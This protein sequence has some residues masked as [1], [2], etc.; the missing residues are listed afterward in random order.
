MALTDATAPDDAM[1]IDRFTTNDREGDER[2]A[3]DARLPALSA[4]D[5]DPD[6]VIPEIRTA[7]FWALSELNDVMLLVC[8]YSV[9]GGSSAATSTSMLDDLHPDDVPPTA[10]VLDVNDVAPSN[11]KAAAS[12]VASETLAVSVMPDGTVSIATFAERCPPKANTQ[13]EPSATCMVSDG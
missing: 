7:A 4:R 2:P 10:D 13:L 9:G 11:R 1:P 6:D 3:I 5:T 12:S 8:V